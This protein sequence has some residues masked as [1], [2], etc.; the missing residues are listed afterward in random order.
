MAW[1]QTLTVDEAIGY[2]NSL[3]ECD[4]EVI[5]LLAETRLPCNEAL[6][7]HPTAQTVPADLANQDT[8]S[9]IGLLGILNGM[10]GIDEHGWGA[11]AAVYENDGITLIRFTRTDAPN[12]K[13]P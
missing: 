5:G 11:I 13:R 6:V 3:V 4:R 1:K 8:G 9:V 2:L 12:I 10:F 7:N